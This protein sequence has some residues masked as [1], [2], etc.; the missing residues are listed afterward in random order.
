MAL[1]FIFELVV[2]PFAELVVQPVAE[3]VLH[4]AGYLTARVI[5]PVL[6]FG[7]VR[8]EH[9]FTR[10]FVRPGRGAIQRMANGKYCM[11][12]EVGSWVG[13]LTWILVGV[14]IYFWHFR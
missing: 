8:V 12:A 6:T 2:K 9:V 1:D 11:D 13:I 10:K 5:V 4:V 7:V 14:G 3:L